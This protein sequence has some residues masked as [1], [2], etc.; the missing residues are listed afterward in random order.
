MKVAVYAQ[1]TKRAGKVCYNDELIESGSDDVIV[2]DDSELELKSIAESYLENF[3][4]NVNSNTYF[5]KNVA[6]S[7]LNEI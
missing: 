3:K 7:I 2:Y 6:D 1:H 5:Y 4:K